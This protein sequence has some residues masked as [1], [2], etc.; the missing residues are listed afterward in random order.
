MQIA[1]EALSKPEK[2]ITIA[3]TYNEHLS[4][5]G[6]FDPAFVMTVVSLDNI[7]PEANEK[8]SKTFFGY[9]EKTLGTAGDRG[10]M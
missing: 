6:T 7:N 8:Y 5:H 10:Y 3:Y 1:A 2:Y 4:F 9:F